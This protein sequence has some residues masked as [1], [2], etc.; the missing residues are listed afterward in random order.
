MFIA[1]GARVYCGYSSSEQNAQELVHSLGPSLIPVLLDVTDQA[2]I[3]EVA[4]RI[5]T[6][7]VLVNNSGVFSVHPVQELQT[8]EVQRIFDINVTG[9][10]RL[11]KCMIPFLK[12]SKGSI[13]N[14]ASIKPSIIWFWPDGARFMHQRAVVSYTKSLA[15]TC[16]LCPVECRCTGPAQGSLS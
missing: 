10:M 4:S 8:E 7:D 2:S 9:L 11:T 6:L 13:V 3:D 16:P 1:E 14:V 5:T 15:G 12:A